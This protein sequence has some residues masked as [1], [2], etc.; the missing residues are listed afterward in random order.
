[1]WQTRSVFISSTFLDMQAERDYLR[2]HVFPE[3]EERLRDRR[4][5][6]AWVDLRLGV[7]TGAAADESTREAQVL[8]LCLAEVQR[9]RPFLI[10]LLGDRYGWVPPADRVEAAGFAADTAGRSVTDL[11]IE[12]G[13]MTDAEAPPRTLFYFRDPLPYERMPAPVA[14]LYSD[15]RSDDPAAAEGVPRLAALKRRI[16]SRLPTRVRRYAVGWNGERV[17]DLESFG[18]MVLDDLWA[19]LADDTAQAVRTPDISWQQAERNA[20]D[21][22]ADDRARDFVGRQAIVSRL[23][24]LCG[25]TTGDGAPWGI[26]VTGEPGSGKS[27]LFGELLRR[28]RPTD[29]F[30]LAHAA[31]ASPRATSVDAMLRRWVEELAT[32]LG[33]ADAGLAEDADAQAVETTFWSLLGRMAAQRRVTVLVDA[34]DQLE[35]TPR[36]RSATWVPRLWPTNARLIATAI[37]GDAATALAERAGIETLPLPPLEAAEA[38]SIIVGIC[39]RYHRKLDPEIVTALLAKTDAGLAA[40]GNPLW[41][42]LAVEE[43]NLL[44]ADDFA[45]MRRSYAGAPAERLRALM[46]D[47]IEAMPPEVPDL[48]GATFNRATELFGGA[49]ASTFLTL[50]A[51][52]RGGWRESDFREMLPS[53][54]GE[55]WNELRFAALRRLFR[56]QIRQRGELTQWDFNHAQMRP[57]A[58]APMQQWHSQIHQSI[59]AY[60]V[61]LPPDDPLRISETMFHLLASKNDLAAAVYY[62]DAA[63]SAAELRSATR[64]LADAITAPAAGTP[65]EG[66]REV[67]RLLEVSDDA[68]CAAMVTRFLK[69]LVDAVRDTAPLDA[70]LIIAKSIKQ[71]AERLLESNPHDALR[72]G[73]AECCTLI[74]EILAAQGNLAGAAMSY[75]E[76]IAISQHLVNADPGNAGWQNDLALL[77]DRIGNVQFPQGDLIGALKSYRASAAIGERLAESHP[78]ILDMQTN[79]AASHSKIGDVAFARGDLAGALKSYR[80]SLAITER[81]ARSDPGDARRQHDICLAAWKVID[82]EN[83]LGHRG[84]AAELLK[85]VQAIMER[86]VQSAPNN[87]AW[88]IGLSSTYQR[89][90]N[91]KAAE[92]DPAGALELYRDF[93]SIVERLTRIDPS[94][95]RWQRTLSIAYEKVGEARLALGDPVQALQLQRDS[96]AIM[97]RL[98]NA[99]PTNTEWQS[100]L[101]SSMNSVGEILLMQDDR[102]QALTLFRESLAIAKR[103]AEA[104]PTIPQWQSQLSSSYARIGNV[105]LAEGALSRALRSFRDGLEIV[106]RLAEA[107]AYDSLRQSNLSGF[108]ETVA[109]ALL[110]QGK[111]AEARSHLIDALTIRDRLANSDPTNAD[112]Q[113]AV[114]DCCVAMAVAD[115]AQARSMLTRAVELTRNMQ[116]KGA[117]APDD[118]GLLDG[119][120]RR[121]AALGLTGI[122]VAAWQPGSADIPPSPARDP[123]DP[124]TWGTVRRNEPCPCGSGKR[125]KHCH[126]RW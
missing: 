65:A 100:D 9:C 60:L 61:T 62:G 71:A 79:L 7:S 13:T 72:G 106:K 22:F 84:P 30:V 125:F 117:L 51:A 15:A 21:D 122:D 34:L 18:R 38:R 101:A 6:L 16:E 45:R 36:A 2:T 41:L 85:T 121:L 35:N 31:G 78:A 28:V 24:D 109:Q 29:A 74:G 83:R 105:L 39:E 48:Y 4:H 91:L 8:K 52:S 37:A 116:S 126:G 102:P 103:L 1:M 120:T 23:G 56:G 77:H 49:F 86:L 89:I 58:W 119:L 90:G 42:V 20:L 69:E 5:Y 10:V 110:R 19:E 118:A 57:A 14:A 115:P 55:A 96:L 98:A 53:L 111:P 95:A 114:I 107:D 93:L 99:D 12:L 113:R 87:L 44:D 59:V 68:D 47:I 124:A 75:E 108:N 67:C 88:Q 17:T 54:T 81:L 26:C 123:Q 76:G 64:T 97:T 25:S 27:A 11:E 46:L 33:A 80:D 43:L 82:V 73:C 3:L 32:A 63:L 104:D 50:I 94:N 92:G 40:W 66:A 112:W 70:R